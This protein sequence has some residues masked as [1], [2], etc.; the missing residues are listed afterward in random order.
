MIKITAFISLAILLQTYCA[1]ANIVAPAVSKHVDVGGV[2]LYIV[3]YGEGTPS[4]VVNSGFGGAGSQGGWE[5]V[6]RHMSPSNQICLYDRANLG[7]SEPFSGHYD[8]GV[9]AKQLGILLKKAQVQAPHILV[10]HSY[11]SYPIKLFN[12]AFPERVAAILLVDP[13]QYGMFNNAIAKWAPEQDTYSASFTQRMQDELSGWHN[14]DQNPEK[15]DLKAS[16]QLIKDS[17]DF[18]DTPYVL[19]WSKN[20]VWRGG[21]APVDWHPKAWQRMKTM[22][23]EAIDK[24]HSLSSDKKIVFANTPQ[25]NIF[26]Y[27]PES[28][29][30]ELRYLL[31][32]LNQAP[33]KN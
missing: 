12:H 19:L 8:V 21:D 3:C 7:K 25:H 2:K 29:V 6:I 33:E 15:V 9:M 22:Y 30:K 11:G 27:E 5:E 1:S 16:A 26:Q 4:I 18:G 24:M 14:P 17:R 23:A 28:V 31:D 32:K 20:G 13:T 10:G